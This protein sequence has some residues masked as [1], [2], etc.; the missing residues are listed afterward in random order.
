MLPDRGPARASIGWWTRCVHVML[1][2]Y[3]V[4]QPPRVA[5]VAEHCSDLEGYVGFVKGWSS[6]C[7]PPGTNSSSSWFA[8][9]SW[10]T[11]ECLWGALLAPVANDELTPCFQQGLALE[12][13]RKDEQWFIA[14]LMRTCRAHTDLLSKPCGRCDRYREHRGCTEE[15]T[16]STTGLTT[17]TPLTTTVETSPAPTEAPDDDTDENATTTIPS[18]TEPTTDTTV[19]TQ[20]AGSNATSDAGA[21]STTMG[22]SDDGGNAT[23][24]G[25]G[26]GTGGDSTAATTT[27]VP[28]TGNVTDL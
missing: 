25:G 6:S 23:S 3:F 9:C 24:D 26:G 28:A 10:V 4:A 12:R 14:A 1:L 16:T 13:L 27:T 18:T 20:A 2:L 11:C 22:A 19:V 7:K 15:E 8:S 5:A 21:T 17:A